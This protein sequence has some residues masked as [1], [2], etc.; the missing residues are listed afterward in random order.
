MRAL[1]TGATRVSASAAAS[2]VLVTIRPPLLDSLLL[3]GSRSRCAVRSCGRGEVRPPAAVP[4]DVLRPV[5]GV[6]LAQETGRLGAVVEADPPD[7]QR[8]A[9]AVEEAADRVQRQPP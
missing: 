7:A 3:L 6:R 8:C 9:D 5:R 4:G 2:L 1:P